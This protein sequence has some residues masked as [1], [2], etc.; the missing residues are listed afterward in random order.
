MQPHENRVCENRAC[1]GLHGER[2]LSAIVVDYL[3][4]H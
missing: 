2:I 1:A 3:T 4:F